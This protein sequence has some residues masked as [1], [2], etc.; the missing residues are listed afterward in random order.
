MAGIFIGIIFLLA[1][2]LNEHNEP[3]P[4]AEPAAVQL[5][6]ATVKAPHEAP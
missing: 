2:K 3:L 1:S 6:P 5:A 4:G